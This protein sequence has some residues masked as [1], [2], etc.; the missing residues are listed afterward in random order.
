MRGAIV[1]FGLQ[2]AVFQRSSLTAYAESSSSSIRAVTTQPSEPF[3]RAL[4]PP[5][6]RSHRSRSMGCSAGRRRRWPAAPGAGKSISAV[7]I[8]PINL[9]S[10]V[11]GPCCTLRTSPAPV[12]SVGRAGTLSE[13]PSITHHFPTR[14]DDTHSRGRYPPPAGCGIEIPMCKN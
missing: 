13:W 6:Q 3:P 12:M 2:E 5:V 9:P 1:H 10:E 8:S 11:T 7:G 14:R 4:N